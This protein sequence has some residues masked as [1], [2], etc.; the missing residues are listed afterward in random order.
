MFRNQAKSA[1]RQERP[2]YDEAGN[3]LKIIIDSHDVSQ[4]FDFSGYFEDVTSMSLNVLYGSNGT[5]Q[6]TY[7]YILI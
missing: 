5:P 2:F 1:G 6:V 3:S 7:P 4:H